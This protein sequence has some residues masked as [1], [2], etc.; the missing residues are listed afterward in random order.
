SENRVSTCN[1]CHLSGVDLS[2]FARATPCETWAC[3]V[4]QGLVDVASPADSKILAWIE[5]ASPD[6]DLITPQVISAE[7][8]AFQDW[9][10]ANAACPDACGGVSCGDPGDGPTCAVDDAD[11]PVAPAGDPDSPSCT[12]RDLEQAFYDDVYAW[13]GRCFPCHFDTELKADKTAPRWISAVGNCQTGSAVSLKRVIGLGLLDTDDPESSLLLQKPL[14]LPGLRHGGGGKF[15]TDDEAY[16]SFLR[17]ASLY[18]QC[19][20]P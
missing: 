2:A 13:R 4:D 1:Q 12:D 16:L 11:P 6:S 10:E 3:L 14:D 7:H 18:Q 17:F 15:T 9:I 20:K 19:R 5:R 8:D